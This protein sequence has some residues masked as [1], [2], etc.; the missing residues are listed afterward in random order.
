MPILTAQPPRPCRRPSVRRLLLASA[1]C[2]LGLAAPAFGQTAAPDAAPELRQPPDDTGRTCLAET[3]RQLSRDWTHQGSGQEAGADAEVLLADAALYTSGAPGVLRDKVLARQLLEEAA[4]HPGPAQPEAERQLATLLVDAEAGAPDPARAGALLRAAM[5]EQNPRAAVTLARL[6]RTG[7]ISPASADEAARL[8]AIAAGLGDVE[9]SLELASLYRAPGAILPFEGAREHFTMLALLAARAAGPSGD[10]GLAVAVGDMLLEGAAGPDREFAAAWFENAAARGDPRGAIKRAQM[11]LAAAG[12][13]GGRDRAA[14]LLEDAADGGSFD[15][16]VSLARLLLEDGTDTDRAVALLETGAANHDPTAFRLLARFHRGDY[17]AVSDPVRMRAVL[18]AA[19]ARPGVSADIVAMAAQPPLTSPPGPGDRERAAALRARLAAMEGPAADLAYARALLGAG[20]DLAEAG[21]R[22]R[23][24]AEGGDP[25]AMTE[26]SEFLRCVP[27]ADPA[28][29]AIRWRARAAEA[30]STASQRALAEAA[31]R[32]GR[33]DEA[34][35]W[36]RRADDL[37]DRLATARLAVLAAGGGG[38]VGPSADGAR[39]ATS[40]EV[41]SFVERAAALGEGVVSGRLALLRAQRRG[42]LDLDAD[43]LLA[44][45]SR[46]LDPDARLARAEALLARGELS[47]ASDDAARLLQAA[48]WQGQADAMMRLAAGEP[49]PTGALAPQG[50]WLVE[51]ARHGDADALARLPD[52]AAL[53]EDVLASAGQRRVCDPAALVALASLERRFGKGRAGPSAADYLAQAVSIAGERPSDLYKV[54]LA[55]AS[56]DA[57]GEPDT[58]QARELLRGA[59]EEG[60]AKAAVALARSLAR[61]P[62]RAFTE[63]LGWLEMAADAG[64]P[65]AVETLA[66]FASDE[67]VDSAEREAV[68]DTL[69][70]VADRGDVPAMNAYGAAVVALGEARREEGLSFILKAAAEEDPGAMMALARLYASGVMGDVSVDK[71]TE[72]LRR[73][74]Q[75][76]NPEA[77]Y[78]YAMALDVGLG[79]PP[80]QKA[81]AHWL[82]RARDHGFN[83]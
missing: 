9:A 16:G 26:L 63:A 21:R 80:D 5:A 7:R 78:R 82:K 79:T 23:R 71:S 24:A 62:G 70:A 45:L 68:L 25:Q 72:W 81:A 28:G 75:A 1:I 49:A 18:D 58:A 13:R 4:S 65:S 3:P 38:D 50:G 73:A 41:E 61:A 59:A 44:G 60:H 40:A 29:E 74:A 55:F 19:M 46:S 32:G 35:R 36:L 64:E 2:T 22:L 27:G 51:A 37:G 39:P 76:G 15:A 14:T 8:L 56:G 42:E 47:A 48:A 77:M 83:Q 34:D 52:D 54:A 20:E 17:T 31:L 57:T 6:I 67:A 12:D 30:G 10:C 43:A 11:H 69:K 53:A 66:R 33:A